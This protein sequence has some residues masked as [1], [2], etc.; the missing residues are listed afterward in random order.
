MAILEPETQIKSRWRWYLLGAGAAVVVLIFFLVFG[1]RP[2]RSTKA[3]QNKGIE[4][5]LEAARHSLG[6]L[7]ETDLEN[8]RAALAKVNA[9]LAKNEKRQSPP[10]TDEERVALRERFDLD[11]GEVA[12][13]ERGT[14]TPLDGHYLDLCFLLHEAAA[15]LVPGPT[16]LQVL[17]AQV[18]TAFAQP[19]WAVGLAQPI[20]LQQLAA[21]VQLRRTEAAFAWAVR[22]VRLDKSN[23]PP[24]PPQ[25]TL[26]RGKGTPLDR[27]LVFLEL[28]RHIGSADEPL[29]GCL[30]YCPG[31]DGEMRLWACGVLVNYQP[32]LY[33]FDPR[34]GLPL[35]GPQGE[36]IATLADV[37]NDPAVLGHLSSEDAHRYDVTPE[38]AAKAELRYVC[39]L[40]GLAPR[41]RFL[42]TELAP[43]VKVRLFVPAEE[44][45]QRLTTTLKTPVQTWREG[46]F[47]GAGAMR[48]FLPLVEGGLDESKPLS[49]RDQFTR[50]I[51]PWS[52]MPP[53]FLD[54]NL[55]PPRI[56][57]GLRVRM[58]YGQPF[59][60]AALE[61]HQSRDNLLRGHYEKAI[62]ELV[63]TQA[64][65]RDLQHRLM[66]AENNPDLDNQI[67]EWLAQAVPLY[68]AQ[69]RA[70][71][72]PQQLNDANQRIDA[73][74]KNAD[75]VEIR[76]FGSQAWPRR[77]E[78][79]FQFGLCKHEEAERKQLR[80][81]LNPTDAALEKEA[82]GAWK[83]AANRWQEYLTSY[84]EARNS[85]PRGYA[86]AAA[87]SVG[88]APGAAVRMLGRA[89]LLV[90][91]PPVGA[92]LTWRLNDLPTFELEKVGSL[93]LAKKSES[94]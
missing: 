15:P 90:G 56:G 43:K 51:V 20:V 41:M 57:L 35:P 86:R 24:L 49:R 12:E 73:H 93:Y 2:T 7:R 75:K 74:W 58:A 19:D 84:R 44:E 81:D 6:A 14:F 53:Y 25:F 34:L 67:R 68:A 22:Q 8:C 63:N 89:Q 16:Q 10:L 46:K 72:N 40:S 88:T 27:A 29:L 37:R 31:K 87:E 60:Q 64:Y 23:T 28:L 52:A 85:D 18:V 78:A 83:E 38:Q 70:A 13:I 50:G 54:E 55:F 79:E 17:A 9:Y 26:R 33:L 42:Q 71:G 36:G 30:V 3:I 69:L 11:G 47:S 45:M 32:D 61:P 65:C 5:P 91:D 1:I 82:N 66:D 4:N 92:R 39:N 62:S 21:A 80:W 48:R 77:L 94:R 59:L 76:L